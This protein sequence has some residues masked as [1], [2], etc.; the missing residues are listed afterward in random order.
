MRREPRREIDYFRREDERRRLT[1]YLR[2]G[3]FKKI[4][5][6]KELGGDFRR[7]RLIF[8]GIVS[9]FLLT[10]LFFIVF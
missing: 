1:E 10:G 3:H 6:P 9:L 2:N 8:C 5:G 7:R 4:A